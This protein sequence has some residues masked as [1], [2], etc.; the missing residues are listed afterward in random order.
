METGIVERPEI[1]SSVARRAAPVNNGFNKQVM[2]FLDRTEYRRC[3]TGE[4]IE[5]IYRLRY[6]SYRTH[7]LVSGNSRPLLHDDLDET[8]NCHR[9]GVF[10]DGRLVSTMRLHHL[11]RQAPYSPVFNSYRDEMEERLER[12][13]T[14]I[15]P[16]RLAADPDWT[17]YYRPIPYLTLR[18]AVIA[19]QHFDVTSCF[20]L[21]RAEHTA[22]YQR[23]FNSVQIGEARPY[24]GVTVPVIPFESTCALNMEKTLERFPFFRSTPLEQRLLFDPAGSGELSP[25][26][27]LPS[28]RQFDRAA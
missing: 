3:E 9:F 12:G 2:Q 8:P 15:D 11:T 1:R 17:S 13:E 24:K 14:F 18:L 16:S 5:A 4:D 10:I 26:T 27:I 23:I 25:L 6:K 22:F 20:S 7:D 28:A 21:I 19:C